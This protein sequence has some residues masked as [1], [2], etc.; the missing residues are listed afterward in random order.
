[1]IDPNASLSPR[2]W[3]AAAILL[4]VPVVITFA[5]A[6]GIWWANYPGILFHLSLFLLVPKLEAPDWAKAAG[7]AWLALD[8]TTGV[9]V[10]D[11]VPHLIAD[12]VRLGGH[13][14][15]GIWIMTVSL[16]G[17]WPVRITGFLGGGSLFL[18]TFASPFLPMA[19]LGP[20]GIIVV[21]WLAF[22]AW[23]NGTGP[24]VKAATLA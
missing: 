3:A 20:A 17:S 12:H 16:P 22:I 14:F 21:I 5:V 15:A 7:Y 10:M 9:L 24:R 11:G 6:P 8:T 4:F 13:I 18:F 23:Q 2:F 1:M 19:A